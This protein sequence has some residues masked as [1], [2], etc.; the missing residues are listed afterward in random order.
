MGTS[1]LQSVQGHLTR[2]APTANADP[3]RRHL[4]EVLHGDTS[5]TIEDLAITTYNKYGINRK[6]LRKDAV[7]CNDIMLSCSP[8]FFRPDDP[9]AAGTWDKNRLDTFKAEA[10]IFLKKGFGD[11]LIRVD[12]HLDESTPHI[13][14]IVVPI[15]PSSDKSRFRLSGKDMFNPKTLTNMQETW[16]RA[17]SRHGVGPRLKKS[18]A[19][20]IKLKDYYS[21]IAADE[22]W[23]NIQNLNIS[24]PPDRGYLTSKNQHESNIN[25]WKKQEEKRLRDELRPLQN[26][27]AKGRLF[28][29]ERLTAEAARS[30]ASA[31]RHALHRLAAEYGEISSNLEL[32]KDEINALRTVPV[33]DV[34]QKLEYDGEINPKENAIDFVKRVGDLDFKGATAWLHANFGHRTTAAA[35]TE[36]IANS[37]V[38]A[39]IT[40]AE[41]TKIRIVK[42]QLSALDA[43]GYRI[44]VV[45]DGNGWNFGKQNKALNKDILSSD[46]VLK[47]I[48]K[49]QELNQSGANIYITPIDNIHE[50]VLVDDLNSVT[51]TQLAE[52]GYNPSIVM[53]TSPNNYQAVLKIPKAISG[54]ADRDTV[55]EATNMFF[56]DI[57]RARGDEKI[58]GLVHPI[59]LAGFTNRKPKYERNGHYP[60]VKLLKAVSVT[61]HRS[62]SVIKQYAESK[63][64]LF[65][66]KSDNMKPK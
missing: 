56:K 61:C 32:A 63:L 12:L 10:M 51:V 2:T 41:K 49:L 64:N 15:L 20:H 4:N 17:M 60:F 59:R 14:A 29:A 39:P 8:A 46:E 16:E 58:V 37:D 13:H 66:N 34:A 19:T 31:S 33:R 1:T 45:K 7:L 27:A 23:K 3:S 26:L 53:E 44:T 24:T 38:I 22:T 25:D 28:D 9:D 65:D 57:N 5:R 55:R 52:Q 30:D 48:P 42:N 35:L 40:K 21:A 6:S 54:F 62:I 18:T 36:Y 50:H 11:R 43:D 47:N